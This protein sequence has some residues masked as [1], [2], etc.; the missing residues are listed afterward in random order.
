MSFEKFR[1]PYEILIRYENGVPKGAQLI[2]EE[3]VTEDGV[4]IQRSE[5]L[6]QPI[7]LEGFALSEVI[8]QT[9]AD[10]LARVEEA[11]LEIQAANYRATAAEAKVA[12]IQQQ[13]SDFLGQMEALKAQAQPLFQTS[14]A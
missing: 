2:C 7:D 1:R 9:A 5:T 10:A 11:E 6:A 4:V 13:L 12:E 14:E 3:G 8:G